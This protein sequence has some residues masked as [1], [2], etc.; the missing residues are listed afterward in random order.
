MASDIRLDPG[1]ILDNETLAETF[2]CS[3]EGGMRRSHRTGTLV[4]VSDYVNPTKFYED[5]WDGNNFYY[6]G[7][8][9]KGD[10]KLIRQNKTLAESDTNEVEVHLFEKYRG[11]EY[12]YQGVVE[13]ADKPFQEIQFDELSS[14]RKVWV[15]P[16]RLTNGERQSVDQ[17]TIYEI[18]EIKRKRAR[19]LSNE[20]LN[21]RAS[22]A[23]STPTKRPTVSVSY[24]RNPWISELAQRRANGICQ[25]CDH[26]APFNRRDG[27]PY[28]ETHHITWLANGGED[29]LKNTVALCPNCHREMHIKPSKKNEQVLR[30]KA[31]SEL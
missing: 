15:F 30:Q 9:S 1:D 4:I 20:E 14:R 13:L 10:Q 19:K 16:L 8:G 17:N 11:N 3:T 5:R 26:E 2:L 21:N 24:S 25:L 18:E 28:L 23:K 22:T 29:T 27:T 6:T 12:T 7:E 31:A